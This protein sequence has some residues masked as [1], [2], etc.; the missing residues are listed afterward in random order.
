MLPSNPCKGLRLAK[1]IWHVVLFLAVQPTQTRATGCQT[2]VLDLSEGAAQQKRYVLELLSA[3]AAQQTPPQPPTFTRGGVKEGLLLFLPL[4]LQYQPHTRNAVTSNRDKPHLR[5]LPSVINQTECRCII[6]LKVTMLHQSTII[7]PPL[8]YL[9]QPSGVQTHSTRLHAA[10]HR[11]VAQ[12]Q[13]FI[14]PSN[15]SP[16]PLCQQSSVVRNFAQ[17]T[18]FNH[19]SSTIIS[20]AICGTVQSSHQP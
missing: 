19:P 17:Q 16:L 5:H 1:P 12:H 7:R 20:S 13:P 6:V 9:C 11:P 14:I 4:V 8:M 18:P 2:Y 10:S 15:S 3:G